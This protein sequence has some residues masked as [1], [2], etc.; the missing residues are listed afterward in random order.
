VFIVVQPELSSSGDEDLVGRIRS[1][2]KRAFATLVERYGGRFRALAYR[3]TGDMALAED[4]VQEA[5][6]KLWT[7]ADRFDAQKAKFTTWFHRIVVNRCLDEKR[8]RRLSPLP[9]GYDTPDTSIQVDVKLEN[10]ASNV[11]LQAVLL[12]LSERQR[13]AVTL[14]YFDCLS[15]QD[16]ADVMD[17]NIKAYES[18]LARS[19]AKMRKMLMAEKTDLLSAFG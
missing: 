14:S 2:D 4:L 19:R 5:F 15:N 16:A 1:G 17:L 3:F 6:V 12:G 18:L 8:K 10:D 11:R 7:H 9:E 13:T